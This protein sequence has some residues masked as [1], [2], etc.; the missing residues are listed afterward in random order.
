MNRRHDVLGSHVEQQVGLDELQALVDESR[1]IDRHDRA[2]VPGRMSER[3]SRAH[4]PQ[5]LTRAPTER[6][7]RRSQHEVRNLGTPRHDRGGQALLVHARGQRLSDRRVLRIHRNDLARETHRVL[8]ERTAHDQRLLVRQRQ[9]RTAAQRSERR[10]Q[11]YATRDAVKHNRC[12][13]RIQLLRALNRSTH[14]LDGRI[15][16]HEHLGAG[17][18]HRLDGCCQ[19]LTHVTGHTHKR[20]LQRHDLNG[21]LVDRRASRTQAE[22]VKAAPVRLDNLARLGANRTRRAQQNDGGRTHQCRL[23]H[24][25]QS[26]ASRISIARPR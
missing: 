13:L 22:H 21:Q 8:H 26:T 24:R 10:R 17:T 14:D 4:P 6:T 12:R 5:L 15:L 19:L 9:A 18:S 2:H 20:G 11:A 7:A 16:T 1:G 25:H 23:A 3:L